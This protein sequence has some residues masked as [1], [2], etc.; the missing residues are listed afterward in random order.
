MKPHDASSV[1]HRWLSYADDDLLVAKHLSSGGFVSYRNAAYHAQQSA[2][3]ALKGLMVSKGVVFPYTHNILAL[4]ELSGDKGLIDAA[5]GTAES[6]TAYAVLNR[7]PDEQEDVTQ[8]EAASAVAA[9][10]LILMRVKQILSTSN[11]VSG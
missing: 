2:E 4:L 5:R 9:A 3:K 11:G 8:E 7:Y 10:E 1:V 6:L